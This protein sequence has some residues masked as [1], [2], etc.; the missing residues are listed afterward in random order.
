[1]KRFVVTAAALV[2]VTSAAD[3]DVATLAPVVTAGNGAACTKDSGV[4]FLPPSVP[5]ADQ[6]PKL[7]ASTA[8]RALLVDLKKAAP[9]EC[10]VAISTPK[11][12]LYAQL[13][14]PL[15]KAC[16]PS[17][18]AANSTTTAPA[19]NAT[20]TA[21]AATSNAPAATSKAPEA[22]SKAPVSGGSKAGSGAGSEVTKAPVAKP[23]SAVPTTTPKKSGASTVVAAAGAIVVAVAASFF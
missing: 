21:P 15:E 10:T 16:G 22:T 6:V 11:L 5:A 8:C 2:A 20:T 18:G 1:M 13:L 7:C 3:C 19:G 17:A 12:E 14:T 9:T 4:S 23:T